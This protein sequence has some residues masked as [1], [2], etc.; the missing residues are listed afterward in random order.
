MPRHKSLITK[1]TNDR[2]ESQFDMIS[3]NA[4]SV[5]EVLKL[6]DEETAS[7]ILYPLHDLHDTTSFS[8]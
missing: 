3:N 5:S 8:T 2:R 6:S 7:A 1:E 4:W